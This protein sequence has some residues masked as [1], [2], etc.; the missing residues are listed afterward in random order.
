MADSSA[1]ERRGCCERNSRSPSRDEF[2]HA[3]P[4]GRGGVA[5][6]AEPARRPSSRSATVR[7]SAPVGRMRCSE[8]VASRPASGRPA[9][10][11]AVDVDLRSHRRHARSVRLHPP[12]PRLSARAAAAISRLKAS[13]AL[14]GTLGFDAAEGRDRGADHD[15]VDAEMT[16]EEREQADEHRPAG[17]RPLRAPGRVIAI[18]RSSSCRVRGNDRRRL[19]ARAGLESVMV[20]LSGDAKRPA[21]VGDTSVTSTR[22]SRVW[23]GP[24]STTDRPSVAVATTSSIEPAGP[25][26]RERELAPL[27]ALVGDAHRVGVADRAV[28]EPHE[29][30][31]AVVDDADACAVR[32]ASA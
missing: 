26:M 12:M 16:R 31:I 2:D 14:I 29:N 8:R 9:A 7:S 17:Q 10:S 32:V 22:T 30:R 1:A 6:A 23:S 11:R 28:G 27:A 19:P 21:A 4:I 5:D 20:K 18:D 13:P 15:A 3:D 24:T 25:S